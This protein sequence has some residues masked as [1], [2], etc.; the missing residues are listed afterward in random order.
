MLPEFSRLPLRCLS[1]GD[2]FAFYA[3]NSILLIFNT[4]QG[5]E[6]FFDGFEQALDEHLKNNPDGICMYSLYRLERITSQPSAE[7]RARS[8]ELLKRVDPF[9]RA[10]AM[11]FD[12]RGMTGAI[13]R[14]FVSGIFLLNRSRVESKVFEDPADGLA[15]LRDLDPPV[16]ELVDNFDAFC[17]T[18][19]EEADH[20]LGPSPRNR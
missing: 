18:V 19:L 13:I 12:V 5:S 20:V 6:V 9:L 7:V 16:P 3:W 10:N 2:G 14:T 1:S 4:S 17:V 8:A 15:W 11:I